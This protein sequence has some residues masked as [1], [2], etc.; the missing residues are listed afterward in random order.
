LPIHGGSVR[1]YVGRDRE[2]RS[3]IQTLLETEAKRG[4]HAAEGYADFAGRVEQVKQRLCAIVDQQKAA[5]ETLAAYGAAAK[6]TTMLA[7]CGLGKDSLDY[8]VDRNPY[9]QG[10]YMPGCRLPIFAPERLTTDRPDGVLLL[11]W[12]FAREI[13]A[14]QETYL[15]QGGRFILPIPEPRI[16]ASSAALDG[17]MPRQGVASAHSPSIHS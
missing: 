2:I 9:K 17:A 8:V 1:L 12:N 4:F 11:T 10:R 5:G 16:V 6:G 15:Q 3:S 14:Q 13:L 7:Y